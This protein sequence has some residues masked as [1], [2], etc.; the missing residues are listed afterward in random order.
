[1]KNPLTTAR[2]VLLTGLLLGGVVEIRAQ[3]VGKFA[4]VQNQVTS[5][6][7]GASDS[8][9]A[10]PG[11]GIVLNEKETTG[12]DSAAKLTFGEVRQNQCHGAP[13][14]HGGLSP[15]VR[16]ESSGLRQLFLGLRRKQ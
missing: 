7:P 15:A 11:A 8:V 6:K 12:P 1:M 13:R 16:P 9:A 3:E 10:L 4:V 14:R 2:V 5:L